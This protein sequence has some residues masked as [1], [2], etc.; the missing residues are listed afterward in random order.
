MKALVLDILFKAS[1]DIILFNHD[2]SS[3]RLSIKS[4]MAEETDAYRD[5]LRHVF[6]R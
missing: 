3:V 5:C 4:T 1:T 6:W 2:S